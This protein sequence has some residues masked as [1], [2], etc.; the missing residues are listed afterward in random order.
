MIST[1]CQRL[2][3]SPR[4]GFEYD[5][6]GAAEYEFG[7]NKQARMHL[8][9]APS[10]IRLPGQVKVSTTETTYNCTFIVSSKDE[11]KARKMIEALG[12]GEYQNKGVMAYSSRLP[13]GWL[14][15]DPVP[16]LVHMIGD[17]GA[18]RAQSFLDH[19]ATLLARA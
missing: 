10:L 16:A 17:D 6:M 18:G 1:L 8:A 12:K 11:A 9:S 13:L 2:I 19:G 5:H 3:E 14:I 15:L 7:S 4:I